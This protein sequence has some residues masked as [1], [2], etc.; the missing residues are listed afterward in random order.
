MH[1]LLT[2]LLALCALQAFSANAALTLYWRAEG[3]TL[4]AT[5]D[6]T[7]GDSVAGGPAVSATAARYGT[8]GLLAAANFDLNTLNPA[9]GI[10]TAGAGSVAM[11]VQWPSALQLADGLSRLW[12][13]FGSSGNN[14]IA[15]RYAGSGDEIE[16]VHSQDGGSQVA[17]TTTA[18][19]FATGNW[20]FIVGK[21]DSSVNDRSLAVYDSTMTLVTTATE[22]FTTSFSG[23]VP[24]ELGGD[25]HWGIFQGNATTVYIDNIF[26]G[27]T[28]A[29]GAAFVTNA[30]IT[31]YTSYGGGGGGSLL[32]RRRRAAVP[33]IDWP[34]VAA[35]DESFDVRKAVGF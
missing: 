14:H 11:W 27:S 25:L 5:H 8:N 7:A 2:L 12:I 9:S 23:S 13:A 29:D 15:L 26:I 18:V 30:A 31:T 19:N 10:V 16:L 28:Y 6:E 33:T 1:K 35:N 4:D 24:S 32:L 34:A 3:L 17:L 21:W 20:Y 22:D